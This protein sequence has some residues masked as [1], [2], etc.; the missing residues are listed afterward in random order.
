MIR[1]RLS[2]LFT[3]Y[4]EPHL[5]DD[6]FFGLSAAQLM[7]NNRDYYGAELIEALGQL[8]QNFESNLILTA[9][10]TG[11]GCATLALCAPEK[12]PGYAPA[13]IEI[14]TETSDLLLAMGRLAAFR[15]TPRNS[16][17]QIFYYGD[18][19]DPD[20]KARLM[21]LPPYLGDVN[22]IARY[23]HDAAFA[24]LYARYQKNNALEKNNIR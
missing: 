12:Y 24:D 23:I 18:S 8:F 3:R 7:A 13:L 11:T 20:N 1:Y 10:R 17:A 16:A 14:K 4:A 6:K 2:R 21:G 19:Y 5:P 9:Q 22:Q 15:I